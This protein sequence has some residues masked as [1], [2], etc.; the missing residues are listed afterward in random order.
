MSLNDIGNW[1]AKST[2]ATLRDSHS[3]RNQHHLGKWPCCVA[4]S[5]GDPTGSRRERKQSE[6]APDPGRRDVR[7]ELGGVRERAKALGQNAPETFHWH[8]FIG[9]FAG[10]R[11]GEPLARLKEDKV[12]NR[13]R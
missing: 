12:A 2:I 9:S 8:I 3:F 1:A 13:G 10:V 4:C 7:S 5:I 11:S 6:Q